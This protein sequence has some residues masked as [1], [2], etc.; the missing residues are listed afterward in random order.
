MFRSETAVPHVLNR[1]TATRGGLVPDDRVATSLLDV[2]GRAIRQTQDFLR[3]GKRRVVKHSV[4]GVFE[5][6][7]GIEKIGMELLNDSFQKHP[8]TGRSRRARPLASLKPPGT[9]LL[10]SEMRAVGRRWPRGFCPVVSGF[11]R[12]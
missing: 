4:V 1:A 7:V 2:G 10:T 12:S 3:G 5:D 9:S 11:G 6:P 8:A